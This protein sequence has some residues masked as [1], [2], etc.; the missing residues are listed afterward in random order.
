MRR[1]ILLLMTALFAVFMLMQISASAMEPAY[2]RIPFAVKGEYGTVVIEAIN[3][4]PLPDVTEYKDVKDG[5]FTIQYDQPDTYYYKVYQRPGASDSAEYD[6]TVYVV[7][8]S[9]FT[10][11]EGRL[12]TSL[13]IG[14]DGTN[15]KREN[16]VFE[17]KDAPTGIL[18][19]PSTGIVTS[20]LFIVSCI[21]FFLAVI[22]FVVTYRKKQSDE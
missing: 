13:S 1:K 16:I 12:S 3:G 6:D 14:I 19:T 17:N 20:P 4:E 21:G 5:L 2:A 11:D 8:V 18:P 22:L 7:V 15:E 9:V 10:D